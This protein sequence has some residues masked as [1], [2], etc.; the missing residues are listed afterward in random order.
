MNSAPGGRDGAPRRRRR[1]RADAR[2]STTRPRRAALAALPLAARRRAARRRARACCSSYPLV[3]SPF[4]TF[5]I[6]A[7]SLALGM[8]ALSLSFLGGYGG[9]ISLAQMTVAGIAG[10]LVAIFGSERA[11]TRSA[12]TGRGGSPCRSRCSIATVVRHAD[13]LAVGAHRGHLHDH[14]HAGDRRGVPL[15]RAAELQR[16]QRLPGAAAAC[17]RRRCSG[18]D[19]RSPVPFYFLCLVLRARRLLPRAST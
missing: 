15:P 16:V 7:Q 17:I 4:F 12:S 14:D 3:A 2:R 5:Q 11:A 13:R 9:M 6:G 1:T 10:Y 19:W 8:I 18:I